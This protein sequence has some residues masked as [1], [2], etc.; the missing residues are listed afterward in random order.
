MTVL[1]SYQLESDINQ[2]DLH[3]FKGEAPLWMK[4]RLTTKEPWL[5]KA[6]QLFMSRM[7]IGRALLDW[8]TGL[9]QNV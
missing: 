6:C 2:F 3:V 4:P 7:T 1:S 9:T 8:T 5:L